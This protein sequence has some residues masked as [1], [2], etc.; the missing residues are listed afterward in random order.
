[1]I[2]PIATAA[3]LAL[4]LGACSNEQSGESADDFAAR[5]GSPEGSAAPGPGA[6]E[7]T[8]VQ[9]PPPAGVDVL[10]LEQLGNI[11]G[12]DLG[13]RD[14]GCTFSSNGVEL[15]IAGAPNDPASAGRAV[16]RLGGK[17]Y[18]LASAG[19]L[20]AVRNGTR[21]SGEGVTVD[22]AA[23]GQASKLTVTNGAGQS[24]AVSGS[25]VCA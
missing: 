23:A 4:A 10:A 19:G 11:A 25:W 12:V 21:F 24:K 20:N 8:A 7:T 3:L 15:L 18:L 13:P 17:L 16:V 6:I 1:M 14:G 22:V 2:R 9:A 5:V